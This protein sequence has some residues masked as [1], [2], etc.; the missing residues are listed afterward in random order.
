MGDFE[1]VG[2]AANGREAVEIIQKQKPDV[3]LLDV[4]MPVMDGI[5]T[6]RSIKSWK[7]MTLAR[8]KSSC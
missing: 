2:E 5:D 6:V 1:I 3:V 8:L 7:R 4:N